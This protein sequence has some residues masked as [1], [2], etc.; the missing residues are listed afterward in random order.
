[1]SNRPDGQAAIDTDKSPSIVRWVLIA[2]G[3]L[4]GVI[5]VSLVIALIGGITGSEGIASAF[6]I[7]RD[8]FIIVLALQGILIS[9][10]LVILVL[11]LTSLINLL[12]N[13]IKP[14]LDEARHT[15]VTVR[16]TSEFVSKN[17]T[18]PVIRVSSA[19]AG[20]RAFIN[21]LAGIRRNVSGD[22]SR[23]SS[24]GREREQTR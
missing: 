24:N 17:I 16:G 15:L 1:M 23:A 10:A 5:V 18:S 19:L 20:A 4:I 3:A 13:E 11:Q 6:R 14:L 8:F 7:L 21:E 22:G 9:V 12:R 2:L